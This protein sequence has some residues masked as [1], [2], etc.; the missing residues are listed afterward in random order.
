MD[1]NV[2]SGETQSQKCFRN[3][4]FAGEPSSPSSEDKLSFS[5]TNTGYQNHRTKS[6]ATVPEQTL[7]FRSVLETLF[8]SLEKQQEHL[9]HTCERE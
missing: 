8:F 2:S 1:G 9:F 6:T 5:F 7:M 3:P 4:E